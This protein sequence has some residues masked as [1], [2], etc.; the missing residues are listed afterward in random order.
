MFQPTHLQVTG[1]LDISGAVNLADSLTIGSEFALTPGG[2]TVDVARHAGT[3][4][5]LRSRQEGFNGSLIEL[6]TVGDDSSLLKAVVTPR[7]LHPIS[8]YIIPFSLTSNVLKVDGVT[9]MDLTSKGVLNLQGLKLHSGGIEVNA[10]GMSV[11]AGGLLVR[12][13]MTVETGDVTFLG[14]DMSLGS[15]RATSG[16]STSQSALTASNMNNH[17]T[18][19]VFSISAAS[20]EKSK[21]DFITVR[22]SA[23]KVVYS[24]DGEGTITTKGNMVVRGLDVSGKTV[25]H[26]AFSH[27]M[28]KISAGSRIEV[29]YLLS[30]YLCDVLKIMR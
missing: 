24:L 17:F 27:G 9:T 20:E 3:L 7:L 8:H 5:E 15:V 16:E 2:M 22:D 25:L 19:S 4:F 11:Q 28:Q 12:G 26:G 23:E 10:G 21:F 1:S 14:T 30:D 18:G 29:K 13:G 6:H